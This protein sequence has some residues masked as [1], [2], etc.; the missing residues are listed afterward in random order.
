[1]DA[2]FIAGYVARESG[3]TSA[4]V[5]P[6]R[7][8]EQYGRSGSALGPLASAFAIIGAWAGLLSLIPTA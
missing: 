3:I 6:D 2:L 7:F 4:R 1:M 8:Y 5:N